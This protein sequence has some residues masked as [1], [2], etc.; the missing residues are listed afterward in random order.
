MNNIIS[1]TEYK[2]KK[3]TRE[4]FSFSF[5]SK[6]RENSK[7]YNKLL[8]NIMDAKKEFEKNER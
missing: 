1:L 3:L 2:V 5:A 4:C 6:E 8:R 7:K